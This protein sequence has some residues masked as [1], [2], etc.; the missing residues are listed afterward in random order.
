M[1]VDKAGAFPQEAITALRDNGL[2]GL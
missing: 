1:G 2:L